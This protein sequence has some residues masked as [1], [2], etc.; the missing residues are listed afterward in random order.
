MLTC[1]LVE[2]VHNIWLEQ[3]RKHGASL[4]IATSDDY[5]RAFKQYLQGGPFGHGLDKNEL[6]LRKAQVSHE[7]I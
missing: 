2:I 4:F 3:S 1:N 5:V 6:L 7:L